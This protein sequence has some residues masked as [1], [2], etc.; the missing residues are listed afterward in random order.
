ME[1]FEDFNFE[2]CNHIFTPEIE[3]I[4]LVSKVLRKNK[5]KKEVKNDL[6]S[7]MAPPIIQSCSSTK[8]WKENVLFWI[9]QSSNSKT[10]FLESEGT[11]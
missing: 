7:K 5:N 4:I 10:Y 6:L 3:S 11:E 2:S 1:K 8:P 9:I